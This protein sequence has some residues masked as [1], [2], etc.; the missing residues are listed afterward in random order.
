VRTT[1][2]EGENIGWAYRSALGSEVVGLA[3]Q[4]LS[5]FSPTLYLNQTAIPTNPQIS[6][7]GCSRVCEEKQHHQTGASGA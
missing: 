5:L 6:P 2:E 3:V 4:N 7:V 1:K